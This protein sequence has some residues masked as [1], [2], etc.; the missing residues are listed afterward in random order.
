MIILVTAIPVDQFSADPLGIPVFTDL[1]PPHREAGVVDFRLGGLVSKWMRERTV[2]PDTST[3]TLLSS[4][5]RPFPLLVISGGGAFLQLSPQASVDLLGALTATMLRARF[6]LFSLAARDLRKSLLSP[7]NAAETILHGIARGYDA[8]LPFHHTI[9]L[10]WDDEQA[11][12]LVQELRRCRFHLPA[13]R[14]W[15]IKRAPEDV[16]WLGAPG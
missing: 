8:A 7:R 16:G 15:E 12:I 6:D 11:E 10:H 4:S 3:P 13:A 9:R 5:G 2:D 14:D 1:M